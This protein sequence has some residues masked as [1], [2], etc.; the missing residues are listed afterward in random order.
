MLI[1]F[2]R[3][4]VMYNRIYVL[5]FGSDLSLLNKPIGSLK[6]QNSYWRDP[7]FSLNKH[8]EWSEITH[9]IL[10]SSA[11][12]SQIDRIFSSF[13]KKLLTDDDR[14]KFHP[15][16]L[17]KLT[18]VFSA[19]ELKTI[20]HADKS[21]STKICEVLEH[22]PYD[23]TIIFLQWLYFKQIEDDKAKQR[24]F[25]RFKMDNKLLL[26]FSS[27]DSINNEYLNN[28]IELIS[29]E[30]MSNSHRVLLELKQEYNQQ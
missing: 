23:K 15:Q 18:A 16:T 20:I 29:K 6:P 4:I 5:F 8:I 14:L 17:K 26:E 9:K 10:L 1:Q 25:K 21:I 27:L 30:T 2:Y 19:E 22:Y 13:L 11:P 7:S 3:R 12:K 28:N 24:I